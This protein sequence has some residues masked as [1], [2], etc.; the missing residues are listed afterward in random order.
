MDT[1]KNNSYIIIAD[2]DLDDQYIIKDAIA[3]LNVNH[4]FISV[5]NGLELM[6][7]LNGSGKTGEKIIPDLIIMDLNMPMLDG[8]G[9]L[10]KIKSKE[11]LKNIPVYILST[12]RFEYDRK[13]V[14]GLG[15][16]NFYNKPFNFEEMKDIIEEIYTR[17]FT[18]F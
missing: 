7:L 3:H 11:E 9:A 14:M 4:E 5:Y 8:L 18:V 15:A 17:T 2:D 16:T 13:K 6:H 12:S 1:T 10:E